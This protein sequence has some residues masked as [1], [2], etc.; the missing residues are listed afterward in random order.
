VE[1]ELVHLLLGSAC[2]TLAVEAAAEV[3]QDLGE[4]LLEVV[5]A[6]QLLLLGR[7][8]LLIQEVAVVAQVMMPLLTAAMVALAS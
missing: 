5:T 3:Q 6:A 1:L 8:P 2:F 7:L 4:A